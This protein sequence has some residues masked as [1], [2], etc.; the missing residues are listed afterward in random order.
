MFCEI[1]AE[2]VDFSQIEMK[3]LL[4]SCRIRPAL[5]QMEK[6]CYLPQ[7]AFMEFHRRA[8]VHVTA[9][10]PLGN[11]N[12]SFA[13][14]D[15]LPPILSNATVKAVAAKYGISPAN[16]LISLQLSVS[17][18]SRHILTI[19]GRMFS[20]AQVRQPQTYHGESQDRLAESGRHLCNQRLL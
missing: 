17:A 4:G 9:Y 13:D 11:T 3:K 1:E 10:S 8:G 20:V 14:R 19:I 16:V 2:H 6:H 15:G 7:R 18:R 5:H 12:P